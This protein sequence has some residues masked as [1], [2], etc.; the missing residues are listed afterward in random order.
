MSETAVSSRELR[1]FEQSLPHV[2]L[3]ARETSMRFFRP[4]LANHSLTEQQWRVLR[5]LNHWGVKHPGTTPD[6][7]ELAEHTFLLGPSLSRIL[8][9]LSERGLVSRSTDTED[10]RRSW[11]DLTTNGRQLVA[12]IAPHSEARYDAIEA[13]LGPRKLAQL[14]T[15]LEDLAAIEP[16]PAPLTQETV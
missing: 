1:P 15:L 12:E 10:Q 9:N 11:I 4:L 14:F 5:A 3:R 13:Q 16:E 2:L 6:V 7:G 8:T